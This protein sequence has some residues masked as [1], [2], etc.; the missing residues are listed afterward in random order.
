MC[1]YFSASYSALALPSVYGY[2]LINHIFSK[3]SHIYSQIIHGRHWQRRER[4]KAIKWVRFF[5]GKEA[6]WLGRDIK[7]LHTYHWN[8]DALIGFIHENM[9]L[10]LYNLTCSLLT[11]SL[12]R[13]QHVYV[14]RLCDPRKNWICFKHRKNCFNGMIELVL[15]YS[16]SMLALVWFLKVASTFQDLISSFK[17]NINEQLKSLSFS[18]FCL[19]TWVQ[20]PRFP[21]INSEN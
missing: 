15:L 21:Q 4:K 20:I 16:R 9:R 10:S 8:V 18:L 19:H 14:F 7:H 1:C 2:Y 5:G 12:Y 6:I 3:Y 17:P 11:P 13:S